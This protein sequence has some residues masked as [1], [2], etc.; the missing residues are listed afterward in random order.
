MLFPC[1]VCASL[2][3]SKM[4]SQRKDIADGTVGVGALARPFWCGGGMIMFTKRRTSFSTELA[5]C[6]S[7]V[8]GHF[9]AGTTEASSDG[10]AAS[11]D[12]RAD[13]VPR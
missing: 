8:K 10:G 2:T 7:W 1:A 6:S 9:I 12:L 3:D 11:V 4:Q 13:D 5:E